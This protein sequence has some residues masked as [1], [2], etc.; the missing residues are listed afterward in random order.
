MTSDELNQKKASLL[1]KVRLDTCPSHVS[2]SDE[3]CQAALDEFQSIP[4]DLRGTC[5]SAFVATCQWWPLRT[6][7]QVHKC[8]IFVHDNPTLVPSITGLA[9]SLKDCVNDLKPEEYRRNVERET[10]GYLL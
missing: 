1:Q 10:D 8:S 7:V 4:K 9:F 5:R 2:I 3:N 6:G